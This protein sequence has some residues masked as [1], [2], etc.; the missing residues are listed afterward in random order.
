MG[1]RSLDWR[2][3][4]A[5]C[6]AWPALRQAWIGDWLLRFAPGVSRRANSANPLRAG[7]GGVDG[8]LAEAAPLYRAQ[9]LPVLVRVLTLLDPAVD[10]RLAALGFTAEGETLVLHGDIGAVTRAADPSVT[11]HPHPTDGWLTANAAIRGFDGGQD[12][13]YRRIVGAI[14]V[15][16]AFLQLR[17][18]DAPVALAFGALHGGLLCCESVITAA[19]HRG[20]GYS[21]R[22]MTTLFDWA[23]AGGAAG[24][25]LQVQADND[26]AV[27]LYKGLGLTT[28]RFRYHYRRAPASA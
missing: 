13:V 27:R 8:L 5:C 16:A 15:P 11:H 20:R 7:A 14:A 6:N 10:R 4:E 1:E 17:V 25:C 22:L 18:D 26:P 24:V 28:E 9:G 12:A 2:I 3:E 19:E 23:A 21:R